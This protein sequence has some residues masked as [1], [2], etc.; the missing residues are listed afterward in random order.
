VQPIDVSTNTTNSDL[1][2]KHG[3]QSEQN[4]EQP[5][6]EP[7]ADHSVTV[8]ASSPHDQTAQDELDIAPAS[9]VKNEGI[10]D[11]I[12]A[13]ALEES[14][15][16]ETITSG[17]AQ[18]GRSTPSPSSK[19]LPTTQVSITDSKHES[20]PEPS[21]LKTN[22]GISQQPSTVT[23]ATSFSGRAPNDPRESRKKKQVNRKL[24]VI[25]DD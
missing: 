8:E 25:L 24:K 1:A 4:I 16:K 13:S 17:R 5:I 12:H 21:A 14:E 11:S 6:V 15:I 2:E 9:I 23:P 18:A 7:E 10:E 3:D 19:E 22:E 20:S